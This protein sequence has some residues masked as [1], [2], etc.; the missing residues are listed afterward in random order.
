MKKEDE[1]NT[2]TAKFSSFPAF[3]RNNR[4]LIIRS[5]LFLAVTYLLVPLILQA[6]SYEKGRYATY[7]FNSFI[8]YTLMAVI[9]FVV[10]N[11]K[12]LIETRHKS[13]AVH[14]LIFSALA[15]LSFAAYFYVR[16]VH[17]MV[18]ANHA[19]YL[20]VSGALYLAGAVFVA[21][22]VFGP[23]AIAKTH[24]HIFIFFIVSYF[25]FML[26]ESLQRIGKISAYGVGKVTHYIL[27]V[28]SSQTYFAVEEGYPVLGLDGFKAAIGP[29]CSGIESIS[30]FVGLF[31]LFSVYERRMNWK[32]AAVIFGAGLAGVYLLNIIRVSALI[33]IGAAYPSVAVETFHSQAGWMLF[34][35]FVLL[36]V[37]LSYRWIRQENRKSQ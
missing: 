37:S 14:V 31:I 34:T 26:T 22:A 4:G 16:Y 35:A 8:P 12:L 13:G 25:F 17:H 10:F 32:R 11:R 9:L 29:P 19:V 5:V 28:F 1:K 3:I 6:L 33:A 21:L 15:A 7:Y 36:L 23:E 24:K 20:L 27:G 18:N 2:G 30:L